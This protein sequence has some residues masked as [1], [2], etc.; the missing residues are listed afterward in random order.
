MPIALVLIGAIL[1]IVAFNNTHGQLAEAL[2]KDVPGFFTWGAAI[3]AI[4]AL[5]FIPGMAKPSRWLLALVLVVIV[6]GNYK[7]LISGFSDF[8]KSG[9]KPTG[10]ATPSPTLAY[11]TSGG[12]S[13]TAIAGGTGGEASTQVASAG[14]LS[15]DPAS[16]LKL[17]ETFALLGA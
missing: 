7:A 11:A 17:A 3:A 6:L 2:Q 12:P 1:V 13:E 4:L 10:E 15:F 16:Y 5:G 9:G 14:G 8:A